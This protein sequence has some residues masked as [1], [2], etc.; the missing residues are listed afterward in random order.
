MTLKG[1]ARAGLIEPDQK[2]FDYLKTKPCLPKMEIG[3]KPI[4]LE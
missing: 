3:K 4:K 1:G 2:F